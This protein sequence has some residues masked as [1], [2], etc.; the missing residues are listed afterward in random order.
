MKLSPS[1]ITV[2]KQCPAKFWYSKK[3]QPLPIIPDRFEYGRNIHKIL[4]TY[5]K[6]IPPNITV[7][8]IDIY[9]DNA[10]QKVFR[11]PLDQIDQK[12]KYFRRHFR[13]FEKFRI[14]NNLAIVKVEQKKERHIFRGV[15]DLIL[16]SPN[17][18]TIVLDWK[19]SGLKNIPD[20]MKIQGCIYSYIFDADKVIF[21]S[22]STGR[23]WQI[24]VSD[25]EE[26]AKELKEIISLINSGHSAKNKGEWC[27]ECEF[28]LVCWKDEVQPVIDIVAIE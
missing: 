1:S 25:C 13:K 15:A 26:V 8:E 24:S 10:I 5:Y 3:Y 4:E 16:R 7:K 14:Q 21:Y 18:E 23:W 28:Q 19:T 11:Q 6:S 22:T 12:Y 2:F 9:V 17:H 20:Y 27:Q